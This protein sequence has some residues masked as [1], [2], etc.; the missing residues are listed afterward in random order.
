MFK[1]EDNKYRDVYFH[2][3]NSK[4][5]VALGKTPRAQVIGVYNSL[6]EAVKARREALQSSNQEKGTHVS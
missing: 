6:D 3:I 4:Y 1:P 5:S 2:P